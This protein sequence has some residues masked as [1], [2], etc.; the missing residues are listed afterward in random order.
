MLPAPASAS[1]KGFDQAVKEQRIA[2]DPSACLHNMQSK[3]VLVL[4]RN[5]IEKIMQ[6]DEIWLENAIEGLEAALTATDGYPSLDIS[7]R[8]DISLFDWLMIVAMI[9]KVLTHNIYVTEFSIKVK[10]ASV[11]EH[12]HS[13]SQVIQYEN[14]IKAGAIRRDEGMEMSRRT[15]RIL[16]F[17]EAL[18]TL[19]VLQANHDARVQYQFVS[20]ERAQARSFYVGRGKRDTVVLGLTRIDKKDDCRRFLDGSR[21]S[22]WREAMDAK[23]SQSPLFKSE[24]VWRIFCHELSVNIWEHAGQRR[25]GF[26]SARIVEPYD[27]RTGQIK[28]WCK[29]GFPPHMHPLFSH[30]RDGFIEIC[31]SDAGEGV[32]CTLKE[33]FDSRLLA[34][35]RS[36][37]TPVEDTDILKF[38][39]DES[40][41][42]KKGDE[43][44]AIER[45]ALC[46]ILNLVAKYG[47]ALTLRSGRGEITYLGTGGRFEKLPDNGGFEPTHI[48]Q[49]AGKGYTGTHIQLLLPLV[50]HVNLDKG[51]QLARK[52]ILSTTLPKSFRL[53]SDHPI[54]HLVPLKESLGVKGGVGADDQ[55]SFRKACLSLGIEIIGRPKDEPIVLDF[56]DLSWT[57]AQLETLLHLLENVLQHRPVLLVELEPELALGCMRLAI[58]SAPTQLAPLLADSEPGFAG[59]TYGELTERYFLETYRSVHETVLGLDRNGDYYIFGLSDEKYIAALLSVIDTPSSIAEL[60]DRYEIEE[61]WL[62]VII[63]NINPLFYM[64]EEARISTVWSSNALSIESNRVMSRHFGDVIDRC[65]AWRGNGEQEKEMIFNL[66]WDAEWVESFFECGRILTRERYADEAAQR[67]LYRL[68]Y[69]LDLLGKKTLEDITMLA[70]VTAPAL[71][72]ATALQ[73]WWPREKKPIVADLGQSLMLGARARLPVFSSTGSVVVIQ[74]ILNKRHVS[75]ELVKRLTDSGATVACVLSLTELDPEVS[76]ITVAA[77]DSGWTSE[78]IPEHAMVKIPRP[79]TCQPPEVGQGDNA[80]W[81]EPRTLR[82]FRYSTLRGGSGKL[83]SLNTDQVQNSERLKEL[84]DGAAYSLIRAGHFA[85]DVRHYNAILDI[86]GAIT[87]EIGEEVAHWLADVCSGELREKADWESERFYKVRGDVTAVLMPMHSHIHYLWPK[88]ANILAQRNRRQPVWFL[89]AT[90]FLGHGP[91][92]RLPIQLEHQIKVAIEKYAAKGESGGNKIRLLILDDA[93][94]TSRTGQTIVRA[95]DQAISR[96]MQKTGQVSDAASQLEWVRYFVVFNQLGAAQNDQWRWSRTVGKYAVDFSF[97]Y[98]LRVFG[99]PVYEAKSCPNCRDILRINKLE[100]VAR[101]IGAL[102]AENWAKDIARRLEPI[103]IDGEKFRRHKKVKIPVPIRLTRE[104]GGESEQRK[105]NESEYADFAI[106]RFYDLM[107]RSYPCGDVLQAL[108]GNC[109]PGDCSVEIIKEYSRFRWA[110]L[111]W[112]IRHWPRVKAN[113]AQNLFFMNIRAEIKDNSF[114]VPCILEFLSQIHEEDEVKNIVGECIEKLGEL[115]ASRFRVVQADDSV[116]GDRLVQLDQGLNLFLINIPGDEL[117]RYCVPF[118]DLVPKPVLEVLDHAAKELDKSGLNSLRNIYNGFT[119]PVREVDPAWALRTIAENLFRG[120]GANDEPRN[121]HHLLRYLLSEIGKDPNRKENRCLL[122]GCLTHF[123][124]AVEIVVGISGISAGKEVTTMGHEVLEWLRIPAGGDGLEDI[125]ADLRHLSDTVSTDGEFTK[126][127]NELFHVSVEE[128]KID[129]ERRYSEIVKPKRKLLDF[130]CEIKDDCSHQTVVANVQTLQEFLGN[131]SIGPIGKEQGNFKA[132]VSIRGADEHSHIQ[133]R[134]LTNYSSPEETQRRIEESAKT[135]YDISNLHRYGVE[136]VGKWVNP[137]HDELEQG[138]L[139]AVVISVPIGFSRSR[140]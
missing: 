35:R 115:E 42:C 1:L 85:Y 4:Y 27:S 81:V 77:L 126:E 52:N 78:A 62:N 50:A 55:R 48:R 3:D 15:Y 116:W 128:I 7:E 111:Q 82:P 121:S 123:V 105:C 131:W 70:C 36:K 90:L 12:L 73:C 104:G 54:G 28:K 64:D 21:I 120:L 30:C 98:F 63:N 26:I 14:E 32:V 135:S 41:T 18:G 24:E 114:I 138:Y 76:D 65:D 106:S 117:D 23:Y 134:I 25:S 29:K 9:D 74:D 16:G 22:S 44:W 40:G 59:V 97:D 112:C 39:F 140:G 92:Y 100:D 110:V 87:G 139:A 127:F 49:L 109:A 75:G 113:A 20:K 69:G 96:A 119:Q 8:T 57:P 91:V 122:Y 47:G 130:A 61:K 53:Q 99:L 79:K 124:R 89:D 45:H 83:G 84:H 58:E 46:R 5:R 11:E 6:Q 68:E 31:V 72:L 86:Y 13:L 101:R 125:P 33:A 38:A 94:V 95:I 51:L 118:P 19:D 137:D 107:Y 88:V 67:L 80:W 17:L 71:Y 60:A 43:S 10:R 56:S 133:F 34:G 108:G 102:S 136:V 103:S 132:C 2:L 129:L 93:S 37:V 66:P